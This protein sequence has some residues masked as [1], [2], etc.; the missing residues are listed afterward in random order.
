[1]LTGLHNLRHLLDMGERIFEYAKQNQNP[2]AILIFDIDNFKLVNDTFDHSTG[3]A[4][5]RKVADICRQSV[6]ETDLLARYGG[7]EFVLILPNTHL[8]H[9]ME[10]AERLRKE[11]ETTVFDDGRNK[12]YT[13]ISIGVTCEH[14]Q[15]IS[16]EAALKNANK[17]LYQA[18]HEGCNWIAAHKNTGVG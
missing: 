1:M 18:K 9:A 10:F 4:V 2:I 13:T 3:D 6:R 12:I 8:M 7:E 17:T 14:D 11:V 16:F 15:E 5:L